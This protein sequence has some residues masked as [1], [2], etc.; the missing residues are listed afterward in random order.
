M[1]GN[2][3]LVAALALVP[4]V[5]AQD[6]GIRQ[7]NLAS[8]EKV[9]TTIRDTHWQANPGGLDWQAIHAEYRPRI[10]A[11]ATLADA[12][13]VMQEMLG[14]LKQTHF[15]IVPGTI[16]SAIGEETGGDASPGLDLRVLDGDAVVTAVEPGSPADQAHVQPGWILRSVRGLPFRPVI[17]E[18]QA[19]PEIHELQLTR[20]LLA[21][22]TGPPGGSVPAEFVD[23]AGKTVALDL[24]FATPRGTLAQFG[25]LPPTRVWYEERRLG[26]AAYVRF[27][28]FLDLP[29][30]MTRFSQTI[31]GCADC[32]G[33]II[34]LRGNPGGIGAMAM[35]MAGFLVEEGGLELG[36]MHMKD[37]TLKFVINPRADVFT[38]PVAVLLDATSASTSE[39]FA[40]GLQDLGR[41]RVF[42][43]RS[44]A[45]ALPSLFELLPNGDG[46]QYAVANYV[47]QGGRTLEGN[48][49]TPDVEVRLTRATLLAGHDPVIDVALTWIEKAAA[50]RTEP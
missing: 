32:A 6:P 28:M 48:G 16:Y 15:A 17:E 47:S 44:A 24:G 13:A 30:I 2:F 37:A 18:A 10:E 43:T 38:G 39:I 49:V 34:D 12:R 46:F 27:N 25:N 11:A 1:R 4:P 31:A 19:N 50:K 20:A 5:A 33:L 8:F 29:R 22:L 36:T 40:G 7:L 9:W 35:G 21:R 3:L 23:G 14:R 42:G 45:A 26:G 41:A